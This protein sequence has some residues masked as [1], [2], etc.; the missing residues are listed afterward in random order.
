MLGRPSRAPQSFCLRNRPKTQRLQP[1]WCSISSRL[2]TE[3]CH[4]QKASKTDAT[5]YVRRIVR[6][7]SLRTYSPTGP[8]SPTIQ[9]ENHRGLFQPAVDHRSVM[10]KLVS[11]GYSTPGSAVLTCLT[12]RGQKFLYGA[13]ARNP[14]YMAIWYI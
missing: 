2:L 6:Q 3:N 8:L 5:A 12:V 1:H 7:I 11:A 4:T 13:R 14:R 10:N 9:D